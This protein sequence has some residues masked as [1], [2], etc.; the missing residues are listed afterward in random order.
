[1]RRSLV[2]FVIL[3]LLLLSGC[4]EAKITS[5]RVPKEQPDPLPPVLTGDIPAAPRPTSGA[6]SSGVD[7]AMANTAVPTASGSDLSWTAPAH[8]KPKPSSAMRKGSY[9]VVGPDGAEADLSITAFPGDVGGDLANI[10]R[11]RGQIS[12]PP[13][14]EADLATQTEHIDANGLHITFVDF[15]NTATPPQRITGAIVPLGNATWFVKLM[16]P[17]AVVA[18]ERNHFRAFLQTLQPPANTTQ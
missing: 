9:A 13:I 18:P 14:S 5:Y 8:W 15:A 3:P 6:P 1:M 7:P 16:G 11:W 12:L 4:R 2:S 17:D 10:N